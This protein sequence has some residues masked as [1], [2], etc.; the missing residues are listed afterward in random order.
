L[1]KLKA[2]GPVKGQEKILQHAVVFKNQECGFDTKHCGNA[3]I[4][5]AGVI[6]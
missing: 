5:R 2:T 1:E 6:F 4:L 3:T